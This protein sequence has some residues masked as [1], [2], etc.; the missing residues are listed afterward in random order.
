MDKKRLGELPTS[1][2]LPRLE[3]AS[4]VLRLDDDGKPV[5]GIS[6]QELAEERATPQLRQG[7]EKY[8]VLDQIGEGGMA[9]V[10]L[11]YDRDLKR[12]VALKMLKSGA[13]ARFVDEAQVL[14]QLQHPNI[15]TVHDIGVTDA[16]SVFYTMPLLRGRTLGDILEDLRRDDSEATRTYSLTRLIQILLQVIQAVSYAHDKG[17][18]H[19]DIKPANVMLGEHGEVFLLDWGLSKVVQDGGLE[20]DLATSLTGP[21]NV[22]GTP[23]Y[24]APEQAEG[25]TVDGRAD[26]YALGILL[27]EMMTLRLPFEGSTLAVLTKHVRVEPQPPRAIAGD[28]EVPLELEAVCL[29]AL[30]KRADDRQQT[31]RELYET[32]LDWLEN[33]AE[34]AERHDRAEEKAREA[35]AQLAEYHRQHETARL[36]ER[37]IERLTRTSDPWRPV[38]EKTALH[39]A[40]DRLERTRDELVRISSR[41][42]ATLTEAC[43]FEA[44]NSAARALRAEYYW[45][46]FH[47]AEHHGDRRTRDYYAELV[48]SCDDGRYAKQ[49]TG[50]G[51]LRLSSDPDGA[52]VLLYELVED[53]LQLVPRHER[54]LGR[55]PIGPLPLAM[56]RYLAV[57]R[58][59]RRRET[60][61]PIYIGRNDEWHGRV[62]LFPDDTIGADFVH[63]PAGPFRS[64]GDP[65][66]RGWSLPARVETLD[67]LFV[68]VHPITMAEY[69]EFLNELAATDLD[70]AVRRSPRRGPDGDSFLVTT[71]DRRLALPLT[72]GEGDRW[73]PRLPVVAIALDDVRTYLGWRSARDGRRYRLP[74]ELEW[75]KAARG[76]DGRWYPWGDRFDPSLCNIWDSQ[77][78]RPIPVPVDEFP[79]DISVYGIRGLGGNVREWTTSEW[80]EGRHESAARVTQ[81]LRGGAWNDFSAGARAAV[82]HRFGPTRVGDA[83]GFRLVIDPGA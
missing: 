52:T 14:G 72:D 9:R 49:L 56:G 34:K 58:H 48:R 27:Y 78:D 37:E 5:D 13:I 53:N 64:G 28:R 36:L 51:S 43:G 7:S 47:E 70:L 69:L 65:E 46:R 79:T 54:R 12:R 33:E 38:A 20:T 73:D 63:V 39:E 74:T 24:M 82:R 45:D 59:D 41:L 40:E 4:I 32:V 83:V 44:D 2:A 23:G 80:L 10:Y 3:G 11:V 25:A 55:T 50:D 15:V 76:A 66:T 57:L 6:L 16:S 61:Y 35:A 8:Q 71:G 67:D 42:V 30:N 77:R 17:V 18:V 22:V 19:R 26:I 31:A 75:E 60:R 1:D 29:K 68:A 62:R 21:G 81:V